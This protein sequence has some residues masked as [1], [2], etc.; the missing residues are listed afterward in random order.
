MTST[1]SYTTVFSPPQGAEATIDIDSLYEG[2]DYSSKVTRA[3]FEDLISIPLIQVCQLSCVLYSDDS[4]ASMLCVSCDVLCVCCIVLHYEDE[5]A[6]LLKWYL[7]TRTDARLHLQLARTYTT[8][9]NT[10]SMCGDVVISLSQQ[11]PSRLR[12]KYTFALLCC[13]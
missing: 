13:I 10:T 8:E 7:R 9:V 2:A 4:M 5:D 11:R 12:L 1:I 3:R 6:A